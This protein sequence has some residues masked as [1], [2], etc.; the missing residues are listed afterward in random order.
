MN[1]LISQLSRLFD[2][3]VLHLQRIP[4]LRNLLFRVQVPDG[5]WIVKLRQTENAEFRLISSY[6]LPLKAFPV[7]C[8]VQYQ[9]E[10]YQASAYSVL[11]G[12]DVPITEGGF[13]SLGRAI[14]QMH[15]GWKNSSC[16]D[17]LPEVSVKQLIF[18][19]LEALASITS[20][21]TVT[22][23]H[24]VA[25]ILQAYR[26]PMILGICHGDA[27]DRNAVIQSDGSAAFFDF[28]DACWCWR[29]YDLATCI[30]GSFRFG[31]SQILWSSLLN[32]YESVHRLTDLE[33]ALLP[34]LVFARQLWWLG[35]HASNWNTW[36]HLLRKPGFFQDQLWMLDQIAQQ[37]CGL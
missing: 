6:A 25:E 28:E 33:E 16:P 26:D 1:E 19:P 24:Q 17:W 23:A 20:P 2:R 3:Q 30:W 10:S 22:Y 32:G 15:Q 11:S 27:H 14:G 34:Y 12:N 4:S 37:S 29:A 31:G 18:E 5:N 21:Q 36:G 8:S 9:G 35:L 7:R 13:A